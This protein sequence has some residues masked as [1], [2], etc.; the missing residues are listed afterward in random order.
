MNEVARLVG[1]LAGS[2]KA[3]SALIRSGKDLTRLEQQRGEGRD[4]FWDHMVALMFNNQSYK[5]DLILSCCFEN[6]SVSE[7]TLARNH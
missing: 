2:E 1:V 3:A 5:V 4:S 7:C 6:K